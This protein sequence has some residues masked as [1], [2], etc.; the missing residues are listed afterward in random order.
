MQTSENVFHGREERRRE[1]ALCASGLHPDDG[2]CSC[3][4]FFSAEESNTLASISRIIMLAEALF[5][6]E[7]FTFNSSFV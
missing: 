5:E 6:V 4:S 7:S 2:T 1:T 3:G